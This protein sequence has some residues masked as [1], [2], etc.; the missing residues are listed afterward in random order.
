MVTSL[1]LSGLLGT[2][3]VS[4]GVV[5]T[6]T[7]K[8]DMPT[9][10]I[11]HATS[12]VNGK[13]Y[14]I[15]GY[16]RAGAPP[17][18]TVEEYD[19][20][21]DIWIT[22]APMPT[23]LA[24]LSS[25]VVNGKI[26]AMGG[27]KGMGASFATM[28]MYDPVTD[29]WTN[30]ADMPTPRQFLSTSV[31]DGKIYAI[32]GGKRVAWADF[33]QTV[34]AYDPS[35]DTWTQ[36]A[37]M[38]TPRVFLSTA[39]VDGKI[40]AIGG[41]LV[42][43]TYISTVE[44]YDPATDTWTR[45]ADMPT[46]RGNLCTAVIG[47]KIYAIGGGITPLSLSAVEVYDPATDTWTI[48]DDMPEAR[49]FLPPNAG[50]VD[51]R[52]Y[53]IGGSATNAG[54]HPGVTTVYEYNAA[55]PLVVD[56]NGDGIVDSADICIMV[57]HWHTDYPLCDIAPRPFGDGIVDVQD[58]TLLSEHL[59]E[60][61]DDLTL[62]AHWALD[63]TEGMFAVDSVSDN[64]AVVFGG[65]VWLPGSGQVDGAL[66]LD[67]V[68][69]CAIAPLVLNP[70][71]GPFSV[72]AWINGGAPGQAVISQQIGANWLSADPSEGKLMTELVPPRTGWVVPRPLVSETIITD[73][74]WHRIGFVWDGTRR[75]LYVDGVVVAEDTW[76]N[77][78]NL[79][80]S[81]NDLYIGTDKVMDPGSFFSGLI[82][83]VRIYNRVVNP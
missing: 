79:E 60:Y 46:P 5:D 47:G 39:V 8:A 25:S 41:A 18:T 82:D 32:G 48:E 4:L 75:N 36:K 40:Y 68:S 42:S 3:S 52:I 14:A 12:T 34:E 7:Q 29:S 62:V 20:A 53:V 72:L 30:K 16:A 43:R 74:N 38:P 64:D 58:L 59:F 23:A 54:S 78:A 11:G 83:D 22:K 73:S 51:G 1:I 69:G 13:V 55:P 66:Q 44:E 81:D 15:G 49:A 33:Y 70:A 61:V 71:D 10:R 80:G 26:Y 6:W 9:A 56:F 67:G 45:K 63:E 17:Q 65:A 31:V 24:G 77:Q 50:V 19:P 35:T 28:V 27:F 57:N 76:A 2:A 37:D 21:T